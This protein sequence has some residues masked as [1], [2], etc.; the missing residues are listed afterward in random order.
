MHIMHN[1]QLI[2]KK[3]YLLCHNDV[4]CAFKSNM[5]L[6]FLDKYSS[7]LVKLSSLKNVMDASELELFF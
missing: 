4:P 5:F 6:I 7:V 2:E 3:K 1:L